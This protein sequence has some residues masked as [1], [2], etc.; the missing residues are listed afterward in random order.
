MNTITIEGENFEYKFVNNIIDRTNFY[1]LKERM[2]KKYIVCGKK[3][4]KAKK[5]FAFSVPLNIET[6]LFSK[7]FK[8]QI[9]KK[10]YNE[11]KTNANTAGK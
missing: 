8:N 9:I 5:R 2:E 3:V 6:H 4:K 11:W 1:F 7:E 10:N